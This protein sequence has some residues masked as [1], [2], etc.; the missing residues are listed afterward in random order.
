MAG[1]SLKGHVAHMSK[2]F[3]RLLNLLVVLGGAGSIALIFVLEHSPSFPEGWGFIALGALTVISGIFGCISSGQSGCFGCHMMALL[4]SAAGLAASFLIIFFKISTALDHLHYK[5]SEPDARK[6]VKVEGALFFLLFCGQMV[7]LLLACLIH[8][9]GFVDYY[10]D[11]E[12][13]G[14]QPSRR[15]AAAM[16]KIQHEADRRAAKN[17]ESQAQRLATKMKQ[18]YG[19]WARDGEYDLDSTGNPVG[20]PVRS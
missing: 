4:W 13:A 20:E 6:L 17:N 1:R 16:A 7:I 2:G 14:A 11:L 10:E 5:M 3:L 18:K 19:K 9:C 8:N 15:D 12:A